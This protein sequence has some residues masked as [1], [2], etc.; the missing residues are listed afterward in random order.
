MKVKIVDVTDGDYQK[1]FNAIGRPNE[2]LNNRSYFQHVGFSSIP[3]A[4]TIGI[5]IKDGD[6]YTM[7][8]TTDESADRPALSNELDMCIYADAD[9][10]IKILATGEIEIA[11]DNNKIT[12]K[13]NGDIELGSASLKKLIHEDIITAMNAHTHSGVTIGAGVTGPPTYVPPLSTAL[14]ATTK[15]EAE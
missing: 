13:E 7:I 1:I 6:N 12:L 3:K 9:K 10:Y 2:E 5:V 15:T 4:G 8:A 14:H 11:N